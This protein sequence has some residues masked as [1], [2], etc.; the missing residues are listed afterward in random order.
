MK[1]N[2]KENILDENV[3]NTSIDTTKSEEL[4]SSSTSITENK[5]KDLLQYIDKS[6]ERFVECSIVKKFLEKQ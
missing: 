6:Q 3:L 1:N 2:I 4:V 5:I